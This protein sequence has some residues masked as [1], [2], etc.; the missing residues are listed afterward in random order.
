VKQ[1]L[2]R[3]LGAVQSALL[4]TRHGELLEKAIVVWPYKNAPEQL[5]A[6]APDAHDQAWVA[7]VP[8][9]H[10]EWPPMW[11]EFRN[12][13]NQDNH[14]NI[15]LTGAT[16][17]IG[18]VFSSMRGTDDLSEL[19][20]PEEAREAASALAD[21]LPELLADAFLVWAFYD[22]PDDYQTLSRHG[23]DEDWLTYIPPHLANE[24]PDWM[25]EGSTFGCCSVS[26]RVIPNGG[27]IAVGAHA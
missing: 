14:S 19:D 22:A 8:H 17:T 7:W 4:P 20:P 9:G 15:K 11:A 24:E 16:V 27:V 13:F 26:R 2:T 5:K 12:D 18:G 23:G 6:L 25:R 10:S 1:E 3:T 21:K